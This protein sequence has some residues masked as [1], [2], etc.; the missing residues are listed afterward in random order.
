MTKIMMQNGIHGKDASAPR[1]SR[2][3][4]IILRAV[5]RIVTC[6]LLV[7]FAAGCQSRPLGP[8]VAPAVTGRVLASD[9]RQP[10]AGVKVTRGESASS[11][12]A[13]L[14]GAEL[15]ALKNP[16]RTGKDGDFALDSERV[17]SVVRGLDW[18]IVS[19]SFDC[20][21]Y[22]HFQTNCLTTLVTSGLTGKPVLDV[23]QIFLQPAH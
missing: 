18:N 21:G 16:V 1:Q 19:L 6:L 20:G 5:I 3:F 8:Y 17:L 4:L 22:R 9:T 12:G 2:V 10:L 23:G 13:S 14:K 7:L 15:L 11:A